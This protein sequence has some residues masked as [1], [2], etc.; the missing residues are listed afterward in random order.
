MQKKRV[1]EQERDLFAERGIKGILWPYDL[2]LRDYNNN[3]IVL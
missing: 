3:I 1:S 2:L